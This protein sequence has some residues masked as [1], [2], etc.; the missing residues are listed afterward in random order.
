M[1]SVLCAVYYLVQ[2]MPGAED[3]PQSV[4][5]NLAPM[6]ETSGGSTA[7][8]VSN[9]ELLICQAPICGHQQTRA[10]IC[11]ELLSYS[12]HNTWYSTIFYATVFSLTPMQCLIL[13]THRSTRPRVTLLPLLALEYLPKYSTSHGSL[14]AFG[15]PI[16]S[17]TPFR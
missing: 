7:N 14:D 13:P 5:S 8:H 1:Y 6:Q 4:H 11:L 3:R 16:I 9:Q 12:I 17:T 15:G 10:R 2:S